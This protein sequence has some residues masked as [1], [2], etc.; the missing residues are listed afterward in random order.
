MNANTDFPNERPGSDSWLARFG[1]LGKLIRSM[2]WSKKP[3]GSIETWPQSLRTAASI[4]LSSRFPT[5]IY[6]GTE[7][8]TIYN[9]GYAQ[10]LG[11]KHP[12][13]LGKPVRD[14]WSEIWHINGPMLN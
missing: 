2:D 4:C 13:A 1:E 5:V 10:I 7:F 14:V 11:T 6:W 9:D 8:A 3:L 12:W